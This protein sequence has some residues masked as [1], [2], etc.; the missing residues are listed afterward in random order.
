M[1]EEIKVVLEADAKQLIGEFQ[2]A[3]A[4]AS[5]FSQ[6]TLPGVEKALNQVAAQNDRV[7]RSLKEGAAGVK[8]YGQGMLQ[9]AQFA[10]D[11][12]YG[13]RGILNNIP[14]LVLGF[15][16]GAGLAGALSVATL[17]GAKLLPV[18]KDIFSPGEDPEA[19]K[20]VADQLASLRKRSE[21]LAAIRGSSSAAEFIKRL[22]EEESGIE[23]Q[24]RRLAL[25]VELLK[26]RAQAAAVV[27]SAS[28]SFE[29]ARIQNDPT[30]SD[31]EKE[32]KSRVIQERAARREAQAKLD[33]IREKLAVA[34]KSA[35]DR[36]AASERQRSDADLL[37]A[38]IAEDEQKRAELR[39]KQDV[40]RLAKESLPG[41][42][43]AYAEA[44]AQE[45]ALY[46][47]GGMPTRQQGMEALAA[48]QAALEYLAATRKRSEMSRADAKALAEVEASLKTQREEL[49]S[50]EQRQK[51]M[52]AAVADAVASREA[53][54][55]A[56]EA[57]AEAVKKSYE[58]EKARRDLAPLPKEGGG[59]LND[60]DAL[61]RDL[62]R[63][64]SEIAAT[65]SKASAKASAKRKEEARAEVRE[66]QKVAIG[67]ARGFQS[68]IRGAGGI[69]PAST[70]GGVGAAG[71]IGGGLGASLRG[72]VAAAG[73]PGLGPGYRVR[74]GLG[75]HF[76]EQERRRTMP[77]SNPNGSVLK[78]LENIAE[79]SANTSKALKALGIL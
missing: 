43:A 16:G 68:N 12:Q 26:A 35:A 17:A 77:E 47:D 11:A 10:D 34:Q 54:R 58:F 56:A 79:S 51:S 15:G 76:Q 38:K 71:R 3:R 28:D 19:L 73:M 14:G 24:N 50:M 60:M 5:A 44:A 32:Q 40:A 7:R 20:A 31:R 27:A 64:Q 2:K 6:K 67:N 42:Q 46:A 62:P 8:N 13:I 41:A 78:V 9:F 48:K 75:S 25:N 45:A 52:A 59:P 33:A 29:L 66:L 55:K 63:I 74:K 4:M 30:L 18:L 23:A 65:Q 70:W 49:V 36:I 39:R 61:L 1:A 21:E 72:G 57:E 69:S 22:R 37:R 53:A